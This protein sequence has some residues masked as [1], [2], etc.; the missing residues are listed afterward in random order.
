[1]VG[2]AI[3]RVLTELRPTAIVHALLQAELDEL[4]LHQ[5]HTQVHTRRGLQTTHILS[6][7]RIPTI[8]E[9][10]P[11]HFEV[12]ETTAE[13][14]H[15]DVLHLLIGLM[16]AT[17]EAVHKPEAEADVVEERCLHSIPHNSSIKILLKL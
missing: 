17:H 5:P 16:V 8:V 11:H 15:M 6:L 10:L 7:L 9:V 14:L 2:T 1:M 4:I 13:V 12:A 3:L